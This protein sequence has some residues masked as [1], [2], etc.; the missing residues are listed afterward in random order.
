MLRIGTWLTIFMLGAGLHSASAQSPPLD[1]SR[2]FFAGEWTGTGESGSYCYVK[3][4]VDGT[5]WV[6]IDAGAGDWSGARVEW[7][8]QRQSLRIGKIVPLRASPQRRIMPLERF[9]LRSEFNQSLGLTWT[10]LGGGCH[11]QRI[12]DTEAR[13]NRARRA[14]VDLP[15]GEGNR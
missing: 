6:L 9:E 7:Q 5:G 2:S 13:L 8:N 3:L 4:G 11:L 14:I 1:N 12:G 10:T 15:P